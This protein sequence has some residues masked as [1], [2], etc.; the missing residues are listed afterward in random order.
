VSPDL[1][2]Q[3]RILRELS[4]M[5]TEKIDINAV[6]S[7]ILEGIFRG[8]TTDLA[9]FAI[10]ATDGN[11]TIRYVLGDEKKLNN[12]VLI[13]SGN[14]HGNIFGDVIK[15]NKPR[16]VTNGRIEA[17]KLSTKVSDCLAEEFFLMPLSLSGT[18]SGL[19]YC[20]RH[21]SGA[22]LDE[23]SFQG[24]RQFCEHLSIALTLMKK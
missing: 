21:S 9:W 18:S 12:S 22:A 15:T 5:L 10:M 16:W 19:F 8:L 17:Y 23:E 11:L 20:D 13:E 3:V 7:T 14:H 2:L 24:F 1:Q 6:I 4:G